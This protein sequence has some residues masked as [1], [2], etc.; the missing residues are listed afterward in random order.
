MFWSSKAVGGAAALVLQSVNI[1]S[2]L[3]LCYFIFCDVLECAQHVKIPPIVM[4]VLWLHFYGK[5]CKV[6]CIAQQLT[7]RAIGKYWQSYGGRYKTSIR[8]I[9]VQNFV[10]MTTTSYGLS[11]RRG[12][13]GFW[14]GSV[15]SPTIQPSPDLAHTDLHLFPTTKIGSLHNALIL[16]LNCMRM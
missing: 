15:S 6:K 2:G 3:C 8:K 14:V 12:R 11:Y 7:K 1:Q 13:T 10:F 16:W 4:C 9:L 5:N